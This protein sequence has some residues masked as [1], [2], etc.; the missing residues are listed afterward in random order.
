LQHKGQRVYPER[1]TVFD[2]LILYRATMMGQV[3][4]IISDVL[5]QLY[6][7]YGCGCE[8][9]SISW[10]YRHRDKYFFFFCRKL[11][12]NMG[13]SCIIQKI[14]GGVVDMFF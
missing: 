5:N 10:T 8:L 2:I 9:H 3:E 13:M 12:L 14:E 11:T 1:E 6:G 4:G 7:S